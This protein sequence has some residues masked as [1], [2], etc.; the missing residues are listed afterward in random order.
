MKNQAKDMDARPR[1]KWKIKRRL[2]DRDR[3]LLG[4]LAEYGCVSAERIK[5]QFWNTKPNLR[6]HY[7]RLGVLRRLALIENVIGDRSMTI[8][9]RITKRGQQLLNEI[10]EPDD[11]AVN[12]RS[13]KTQFEHDQLLID[14]RR[15]LE[16]SPIVK[17]FKT[18]SEVRS[19][20][21][22][23]KARNS[24]WEN[25]PA[26]PDGTFV[27]EVPGQKMRVAIELE[28]S[29]KWKRRYGKIF[30]DH[31]LS[32]DWSLVFYIVKDEQLLRFLRDTLAETKANDAYVR[33][34]KAIN[35]IYFCL[36]DDFLSA[37]LGVSFSNG[38]QE[39]SLERIAKNF[40]L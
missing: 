12:R 40:E 8:G 28:L 3:R 5:A 30:R 11:R 15:I 14:V 37:Q 26:I 25:M 23:G 22:K 39:L 34:S 1:R 29:P 19:E 10:G 13:Y 17:E 16:R 7:R 36:L 31:I 21:I 6:S 24:N 33:V 9:Y 4:F 27:F 32:K 38:K 20:L 18:E 2:T 35:G